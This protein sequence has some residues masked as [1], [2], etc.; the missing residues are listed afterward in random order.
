LPCSP[1][2][3]LSQTAVTPDKRWQGWQSTPDRLLVAVIV[4]E[5]ST[6]YLTGAGVMKSPR[7][8]SHHRS[9][10]GYLAIV[11]GLGFQTIE[12]RKDDCL[13][14]DLVEPDVNFSPSGSESLG[15]VS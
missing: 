6:G 12:A 2:Q 10:R 5:E 13:R 3:W 1:W 7:H 14:M 4:V 11:G 15:S 9:H 8:R